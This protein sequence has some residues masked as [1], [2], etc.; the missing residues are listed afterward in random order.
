MLT[1]FF[2]EYA[3]FF[4]KMVTVVLV[5]LAV[6]AT[7]S[8][9]KK[10][11]DD[12]D[13]Q[14]KL[15]SL[16]DYYQSFARQIEDEFLDKKALKEKHKAEKKEAQQKNS[17]ERPRLFVI[18]FDGDVEA[19]AV[20]DLRDQISAILQVAEEED[21]VLLRLESAGGYVYAYGLAASQL[22]RLRDKAV[23]LV[24][25]VDKV[26]ASGGY[27]MACV[28][29]ELLAAPFALVGSIGVIG[30]LPNFHD[31]LR[32]N[33][34]HY[35]QHTA[36]QYKRTLTVFGQNTED[37]RKQFRHELAETHALFK[38]HIQAMRPNL[39]VEEVATGE[40][41]YGSQA[42]AKGL[43]DRVQTSDDYVLSHLETHQILLLA[44]EEEESLIS[45]LK[46]QFFGKIKHTVPFKSRIY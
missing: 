17:D 6:I 5:I 11:K 15:T 29:D 26:A 30:E 42:L 9:M 38:A 27:M 7:I 20:E 31:L 33:D 28:A 2:A 44:M 40:T 10:S 18:D 32:K 34:I 25:A 1:V 4:A 43:I 14:L 3:L 8:L 16:N 41:W 37:D 13:K 21:E 23:R 12:E 36:G 46:Y 22:V 39:A 24:I 35:E 19:S 45:Q